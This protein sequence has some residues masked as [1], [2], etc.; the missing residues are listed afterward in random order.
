MCEMRRGRVRTK[1]RRQREAVVDARLER[2]RV[3]DVLL[4]LPDLVEQSEDGHAR[5]VLAE[6]VAVLEQDHLYRYERESASHKQASQ[7][8]QKKSTG[9]K[10]SI[11]QHTKTRQPSQG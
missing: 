1:V 3:V 9:V 5:H 4:A 8:L 7:E 2:T 6:V 11:L 10:R